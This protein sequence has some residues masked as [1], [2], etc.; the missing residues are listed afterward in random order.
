MIEA[1]NYMKNLI[2]SFPNQLSESLEI[3]KK[4]SFKVPLHEIQN[5]VMCGMGGSGIGGRIVSQWLVDDLT[6]PVAFC[7]DYDLPNFVNKNTLF[8]ASSYSGNTEETLMCLEKAIAK[9]AQ[10]IAVTSGGKLA[11]ICEKHS[12]DYVVV[13][14]GNPPRA[15]LA[16]SIVQLVNIL[17]SLKMCP[18]Q[19]MT[20]IQ[21]GHDLIVSNQETI[22]SEAD[23]L[24]KA[25]IGKI[26]VFYASA[27]YEG[28]ALRAR[29]QFNE[30]SK[31]IGMSNV[32]PEM[33]H[34]ELVGWS[35]GD[36]R[37]GVL[38]LDTKDL[39]ERNQKRVEITLDRIKGKT[40]TVLILEAKG[41]SKIEK[42]IYLSNIIDWLS[43]NIA[44]ANKVDSVEIEI[45][46][47][48]KNSLAKL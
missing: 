14:G 43:W 40:D 29:Q 11:E 3:A 4:Q 5:I 22:L 6:V 7:Q 34:N 46:D 26:P 32:I 47:F 21:A 35:G 8:L 10:V 18:Q 20:E 25:L 27:A 17:S 39:N 28:L 16:Y 9:G 13:P 48:L 2:T 19:R 45:I 12:F 30:N 15:A 23:R 42:T 1:N 33:N 41:N 44:D 38:Y 24:T 31:I 36:N 37:F